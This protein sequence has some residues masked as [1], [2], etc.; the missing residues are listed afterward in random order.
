MRMLTACLVVGLCACGADPGAYSVASGERPIIQGEA[1]GKSQFPSALALLVD[2]NVAFQGFGE[3]EIKSVVCGGTLIAP[4]V[5][6]TAAH[7]LDATALTMGL[8]DV[9]RQRYFVTPE[10]ELGD[11][12]QQETSVFPAD[13][14]EAAGWVAHPDFDIDDMSAVDGPGKFSDIA[15]VFL[16][17]PLALP[18][19]PVITAEEA[20][21]LAEGMT[22][23]IVGWG[24]QTE[25]SFWQPPPAGT[26]GVKQCATSFIN[27]LGEFEM[28][29][30]DQASRKCH[31]DSGGPS[32]ADVETALPNTRRVVG[33]TSHAYDMEDCAK[34]G[35]DTR[36]DAWLS[37]LD[38]E[39]KAACE[40]DLRS[41]CD[42]PG[43]LP[44]DAEVYA[45]LPID[46][47]D[48]DAG[49]LQESAEPEVRGT[50]SDDTDDC[51]AG[52]PA[53]WV[54]LGLLGL[55]ARRRRR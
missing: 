48:V 17:Q 31:G 7:C 52:G 43:L 9:E 18:P 4:D 11:L 29:V 37:W 10:T 27:E 40:D 39:M 24:Q 22:V 38:A 3:Q 6:L 44:P 25:T 21:Q 45:G 55:A 50:R 19:T 26:V 32:F 42:L 51:A 34:G 53:P 28:Q 5:V 13:A 41:W 49:D 14:V 35:V 15:L 23:D 16:K 30:G 20:S 1:C 33:V 47:P 36:V 8:G 2:A 54:G 46:Q 12:A